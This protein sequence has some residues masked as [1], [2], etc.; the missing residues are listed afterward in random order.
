MPNLYRELFAAPGARGFA[1]AGLVARLSLPMTHMGI[2]TML[3]ELSGRYGLASAVAGTFTLSMALIGPQVSRVVDRLGQGRVLVPATGISVAALGALILCAYY[4]GPMWTLFALAVLAGFM[5]SMG[6]MVRARWT[7]LYRGSPKLNTAY[8]LESVVDELTYIIGPALAVM[9]CTTLLPAAGPALAAALLVAGVVLFTAQKRT[10]PPV[11]P[12]TQRDGGSAIRSGA[13]LILAVTLLFGGA[14]AGT[15]DTLGLAFAEQQ[16][17]KGAASI[18]FSAYA[19]GS[20]LSG[21]VFGART[22]NVRPVRLLL[23][24]VAGTAATT[25]P[26]LVVGN[27]M[28]LSL[29]VFFAGMFFAPTMIVVMGIAEQ[30]V[31]AAKLTEGM[32]WLIAGLSVGIALGAAVSGQVVDALGTRA[33]FGVAIAAGAL[34]LLTVVLAYRPLRS[35]TEAK[36]HAPVGELA[37]CG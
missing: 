26:F 1:S 17:Q 33:G 27:V 30:V 15:V 2:L 25:L 37:A 24:G 5:P 3:S 34:G 12:R 20:G 9:L 8:S 23:F 4:E 29:A 7:E 22:W 36:P 35:R 18:V 11:R 6:A 16:G 28:T 14:I 13:V 10:E 21:L 31:P 19:L 32:T